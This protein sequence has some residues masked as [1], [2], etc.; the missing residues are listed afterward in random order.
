MTTSPDPPTDIPTPLARALREA[1]GESRGP[2]ARVDD[3]IRA[4]ARAR[5]APAPTRR[6]GAVFGF[7]AVAAAAALVLYL[8]IRGG[9]R[10]RADFD[11][12]G[13]VDVRDAFL[14]ARA[15][16]DGERPAPEW[17]V[18]ADGR[19]DDADVDFVMSEATQL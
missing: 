5:I 18:N 17:D 7:V 1:G 11:G 12:N 13:G 8:S 10:L 15:L 19:V 6:R 4:A 2:S 9:E 16:R 14:L 3:A